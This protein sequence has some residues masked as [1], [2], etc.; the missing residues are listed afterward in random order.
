MEV[1]QEVEAEYEEEEELSKEE[2]K[3]LREQAKAEKQASD[4]IRESQVIIPLLLL[5]LLSLIHPCILYSHL[6]L[7]CVRRRCRRQHCRHRPSS[8]TTYVATR[9]RD[10]LPLLSLGCILP[11]ERGHRAR[12]G[13]ADSKALGFHR[14]A[15]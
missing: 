13:Q 14:S 7:A 11:S 4:K 5:L 6:V 15:D 10:V 3:E 1:E 9:P 8:G 12:H 2:R